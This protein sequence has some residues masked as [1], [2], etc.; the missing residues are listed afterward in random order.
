M[1][2]VCSVISLLVPVTLYRRNSSDE[3]SQPE[4]LFVVSVIMLY[5]RFI[6]KLIPEVSKKMLIHYK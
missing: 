4:V 2:I 1:L 3:Q 6:K 5:V